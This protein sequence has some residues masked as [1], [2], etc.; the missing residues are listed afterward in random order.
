MQDKL[1]QDHHHI[2]ATSQK[3]EVQYIQGRGAQFNT[4]NRFIKNEST[5]EHIEGID[6]WEEDNVRTQ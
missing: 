4:K 1:Q 2:I 3:D 6:I 5:K